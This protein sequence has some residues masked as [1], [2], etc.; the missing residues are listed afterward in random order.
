MEKSISLPT[1]V[2]L[3]YVEQGDPGGTPVIFLHGV[4]DSWHSFEHVL[5]LLT[6]NV[7]ALASSSGTTPSNECQESVT[8]CRKITGVPPGSPC[9]T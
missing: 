2:R 4:T 7:R 5:P 9:S 6:T 8:P 1:G 3:G